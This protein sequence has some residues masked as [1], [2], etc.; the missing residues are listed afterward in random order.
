MHTLK[1]IVRYRF[2]NGKNSYKIE[3]T[4]PVPAK[5]FWSLTAYNND[6][7]FDTNSI[8][9]YS[10]GTGT[11]G[12]IKNENGGFTLY[13]SLNPPADPKLINN[14][15]PVPK[16]RFNVILRTYWPEPNMLDF[17]YKIP[18]LVRI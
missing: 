4:S 2:L 3:F 12:L 14:W 17:S 11:T 16:D 5:G 8:G 9:R 6:H 15:L 7:Y 1:H 18:K 13:L 10:I